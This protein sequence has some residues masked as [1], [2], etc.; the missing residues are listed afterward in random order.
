MNNNETNDENRDE[1]FWL[2]VR[3]A[4]LALF[5]AVP[6]ELRTAPTDASRWLRIRDAAIMA[7]S[8]LPKEMQATAT[9]QAA[10]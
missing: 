6:E 5:A 7:W 1:K 3:G 8:A 9:E 2:A 4:A 10:R